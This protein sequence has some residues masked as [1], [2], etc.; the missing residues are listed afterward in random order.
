MDKSMVREI[1]FIDIDSLI[2]KQ[3]LTLKSHIINVLENVIEM[4]ND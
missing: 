2:E 4:V 1:M 3:H